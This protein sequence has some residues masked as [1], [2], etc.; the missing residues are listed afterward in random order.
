MQVTV[1][2]GIRENTGEGAKMGASFSIFRADNKSW[3]KERIG[4]TTNLKY[5]ND[6][7]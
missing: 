4:K 7:K 3:D 6:R 5:F 1:F 2:P